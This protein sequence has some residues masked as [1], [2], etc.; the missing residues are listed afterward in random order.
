[1]MQA[2][3]SY[4][5]GRRKHKVTDEDLHRTREKVARK[6]EEELGVEAEVKKTKR[7]FFGALKGV[8]PFTEED[9][10]KGQLDS[11]SCRY[12]RKKK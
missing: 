1:M 10:L 7:N 2:F 5:T 6:M 4:G 11:Q 8:A 9:K 12:F 3:K